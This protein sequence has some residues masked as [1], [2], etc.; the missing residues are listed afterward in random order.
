MEWRSKN[1]ANPRDSN[2]DRVARRG[3]V[4]LAVLAV[5]A[6]LSLAAW[7]FCDA[8]VSENRA[9]SAHARQIERRVI[10]DSGIA[11]T[12]ARLSPVDRKDATEPLEFE[13]LFAGFGQS[14]DGSWDQI[15]VGDHGD[16]TVLHRA[17]DSEGEKISAVTGPYDLSGLININAVRDL[18]A[19]SG[20]DTARGF[21]LPLPNLPVH[22]ADAILDF[23]AD[24]ANL[25]PR[26]G[27]ATSARQP[28][29]N[30]NVLLR[31][32]GV[33][34]EDVFGEDLNN[35]GLLDAG[36]DRNDDGQLQPGWSHYLTVINGVSNL[37]PDRTRKIHLNQPSLATLYDEVAA[38]LGPRV[39]QYVVALRMNGALSDLFD[40]NADVMS[41]EARQNAALERGRMQRGED[42]QRQSTVSSVADLSRG[43]LDLSVGPVFQIESLVDLF[44]TSVRTLVDGQDS[45]LEAPWS[46]DA[47][48]ILQQLPG[49]HSHLTVSD[50]SITAGQIN[51]FVAP[52][53]VLQSVPGVTPYVADKIMDARERMTQ[54]PTSIAWLLDQGIMTHQQL[55][56]VAPFITAGG[57]Y[58]RA[59]IVA[60]TTVNPGKPNSGPQY[61]R[62][63]SG[64]AITIDATSPVPRLVSHRELTPGEC[65]AWRHMLRTPDN[66]IRR[67]ARS[68]NR[69]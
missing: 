30:L 33:S 32:P 26:F 40:P 46:S 21:L 51:V 7:A 25:N 24:P 9:T 61:A 69:Y 67:I 4:L 3:S 1:I 2:C 48:T 59:N 53:V 19:N 15:A 63:L 43:G 20:R 44:G 18:D 56:K 57:D 31:V 13:S 52:H 16:F 17:I 11:W 28:I 47:T 66:S 14:T 62:S 38:K 10:V 45:V 55:R 36:E 60:D 23:I 39:A 37:R 65:K 6:L 41:A 12:A 34:V 27:T 54:P 58:F 35:N 49:L 8:M 50:E 22:T 42:T 29:V 64:S 5:I 68:T